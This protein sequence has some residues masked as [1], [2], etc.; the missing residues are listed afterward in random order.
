MAFV[1]AT[2]AFVAIIALLMVMSARLAC[3][4]STRI[5]EAQSLDVQPSAEEEGERGKETG[6]SLSEWLRQ[7]SSHS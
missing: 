2:A 5:E 7:S 3:W 6:P 4:V 1:V